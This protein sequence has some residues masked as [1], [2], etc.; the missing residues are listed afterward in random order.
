MTWQD[1]T[2][3]LRPHLLKV[4][5]NNLR[6]DLDTAEDVVQSAYLEMARTGYDPAKGAT[7]KTWAVNHVR[8][9]V[10]KH[11]ARTPGP[12]A[13]DAKRRG[14]CFS[15]DEPDLYGRLR[16]RADPSQDVWSAIEPTLTDDAFWAEVD[17]LP[18]L[19]SEV[20]RLF[21]EGLNFAAISE[22]LGVSHQSV[23]KRWRKA[24]AA[25]STVFGLEAA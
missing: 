25:L 4:A 13:E 17:R 22:E 9:M 12:K 10:H 24:M 7:V 1:E 23:R 21:G 19:Q 18:P 15:M 16:E 11:A 2:K 6:G 14:V 20:V 5:R 3:N 8:W